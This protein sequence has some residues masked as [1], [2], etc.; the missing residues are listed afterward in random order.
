MRAGGAR[1]AQPAGFD[2]AA[3]AHRRSPQIE[4]HQGEA[5]A[6]QHLGGGQRLLEIG[7]TDPEQTLQINAQSCRRRRIERVPEIDQG[8]GFTDTGGC[9]QRREQSR[10]AAAR[11]AADQLDQV[12]AREPAVEQAVE[13][14]HGSDQRRMLFLLVAQRA[15]ELAGAAQAAPQLLGESRAH[16]LQRGFPSP[17]GLGVVGEGARG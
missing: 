7:G 12:P 11:P 8:R 6:D 10:E 16:P 15:V 3:A 13:G 4:H 5:G 1:Q 2:P 17:A 14:G 9:G